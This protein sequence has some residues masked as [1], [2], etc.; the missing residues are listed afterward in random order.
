MIMVPNSTISISSNTAILKKLVFRLFQ[1]YSC[2]VY[3][4]DNKEYAVAMGMA[5]ALVEVPTISIAVSSI[6]N[7]EIDTNHCRGYVI[8][9]RN[10]TLISAAL[11][12]LRNNQFGQCN[13]FLV[14]TEEIDKLSA[15]YNEGMNL[16][17]LQS[18]LEGRLVITWNNRKI[19]FN[20]E[21]QINDWNFELTQKA[22]PQR[23]FRVSV[24]NCTPHV[25]YDESTSSYDGTEYRIVS[26]ITK[27]WDV[28]YIFLGKDRNLWEAL[29]TEV[30]KK[31]ADLGF[32]YLWQLGVIRET[33]P[34]E[35][36]ITD[37]VGQHCLTVLV[38]KPSLLPDSSYVFQP[39]KWNI[40]IAVS[41]IILL[42]GKLLHE[43]SKLS[44]WD[45]KKITY[46]GVQDA[47]L[48]AIQIFT[49]GGS[50]KRP[51][52]RQLP[53]CLI[54]IS[55]SITFVLLSTAYSAGS[56]S[57]STYPPL[58]S[59]IRTLEDLTNKE[60]VVEH[61]LPSPEFY[62]RM[63]NASYNP[64]V[65]RLANLL[66]EV[67]RKGNTALRAR[68]ARTVGS[69]CV[70]NTDNYTEYERTHLHLVKECVYKV[71]TVMV[72]QGNSPYTDYFNKQVLKL[73]EFGLDQYWLEM[74][75]SKTAVGYMDNFYTSYVGFDVE[76]KSLTCRKLE[77]AFFLLVFGYFCSLIGF[78][79]EICWHKRSGI[80][81]LE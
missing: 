51:S 67:D 19:T 77:G 79:A 29:I 7:F 32:C 38:P 74:A 10:E 80:E 61:D 34:K 72:L 71:N 27:G 69:R 66:V 47:L 30:R 55:F 33:S 11:F 26:E 43:V 63:F 44:A 49:Y 31:K 73:K 70:M 37:P 40:W 16:I 35:I 28:E 75:I 65:R 42:G 53:L 76:P 8:S 2:L 15:T 62:K 1:N 36:A 6:E 21:N 81:Y 78:V 59:P 20:N 45:T 4:S 48:C 68:L 25:I 17:F 12:A 23:R 60:M 57:I 64:S 46:D 14:H 56:S 52:L 3:I 9:A 58:S 54:F 24:F 39:M 50:S 5:L 22:I 13:K 41:F 18:S